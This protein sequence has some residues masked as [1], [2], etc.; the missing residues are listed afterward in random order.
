MV[1]GEPE[2]NSLFGM[3]GVSDPLTPLFTGLKYIFKLCV[4]S[5]LQKGVT[6]IITVSLLGRQYPLIVKRIILLSK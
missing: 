6:S 5:P 3:G 2:R 1:K 4:T